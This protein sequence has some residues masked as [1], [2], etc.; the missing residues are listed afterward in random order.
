[1]TI[2]TTGHHFLAACRVDG[3][4]TENGA[5][6]N[7]D[8]RSHFNKAIAAEQLVLSPGVAAGWNI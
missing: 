7:R 6:Q 8:E 5:Q 1:M 3:D 2:M 4:G